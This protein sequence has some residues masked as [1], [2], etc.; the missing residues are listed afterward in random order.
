MQTTIRS[1]RSA[2][3]AA[4]VALLVAG[5]AQ[6]PRLGPLPQPKPVA[7]F[8]AG[9]SLAGAQDDGAARAWPGD[10]WWTAYGDTQLNTLMDEALH[11]APTLAAAQ[12][13]LAKALAAAE[14]AGAAL[15]PEVNGTAGAARVKQSYNNGIP[16]AFVPQGWNTSANL[17]LSLGWELDFWG[18]NRAALA[19]AT[20]A[21]D[22]SQAERAQAR[23]ALTTAIGAGYAELARLYASRATAVQAL[24]VR[25]QTA[26]L[27]A[28]R[29]NNGLETVGGLRQVEAKQA[30]AEAEL[31]ALDESIQ[32]QKQALAALLGAGPDRALR[33]AA[34][35]V[36][37]AQVAAPPAVLPADLIGRRP[38]VV[39]A[40]LRAAS[41]AQR[42]GQAE[43]AFYPN[44]NLSATIGYQALGLDLLAKSGSLA[45]NVGPAISLPIF[46][47]ARLQG[48]YKGARADYEE[49]VANYDE[50]VARALR[51]VADAA[52]SQR[53]LAGRLDRMGAAVQAA[54]EAYR[55]VNNRYRG[56]LATY[57]DVLG[58]EDALLANARELTA[59]RSRMFALNV[60]MVRALGGG[61]AAGNTKT[62]IKE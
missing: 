29:Q 61:Y 60:Q 40:R 7:Q 44:V 24:E 8:D 10:A 54:E 25:R 1:G 48:Q 43:A 47:T 50:A 55:V 37:L 49:A 4:A 12:A 41:F 13:R 3:A 38:D 9:A 42:I 57:L 15:R 39:A 26:A 31:L 28:Q 56:G 11:D 59:L 19:A 16:A 14:E 58:A 17:G 62:L 21:A 33:I 18:R 51:E 22:A 27:F 35:R 36:D 6:V 30:L 45:G 52:A 2:A 23:L 53:A 32:L 46:N 5:C 34:P 20:S